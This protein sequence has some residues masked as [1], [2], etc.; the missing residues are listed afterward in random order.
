VYD[1]IYFFTTAH[2]NK[3]IQ[4]QKDAQYEKERLEQERREEL[5]KWK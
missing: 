2:K 1:T 5:G 4:Q 3:L